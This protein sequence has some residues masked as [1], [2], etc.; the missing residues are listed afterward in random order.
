ML[1]GVGV[2]SSCSTSPKGI[3]IL[4]G[5]ITSGPL[6]VI[7]DVGQRLPAASGGP[8]VSGSRVRLP[9]RSLPRQKSLRFQTESSQ[10]SELVFRATVRLMRCS[11]IILFN[12]LVSASKRNR[13]AERLR[14]PLIEHPLI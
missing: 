14:S 12:D 4:W 13:H 11:K 9:Q 8:E 1:A 2:A 6:N 7:G 10:R 3:A 5:S